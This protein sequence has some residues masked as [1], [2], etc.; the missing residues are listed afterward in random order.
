M[1]LDE[2]K[3]EPAKTEKNASLKLPDDVEFVEVVNN[4]HL[5]MPVTV[6]V[7]QNMGFG[8][9]HC[10]FFHATPLGPRRVRNFSIHTRNFG[11]DTPEEAATT[12]RQMIEFNDVIFAQDQPVVES[13]RPEDLPEDLSEELHLKGVDT[14]SVTYRRWLK[15]L[16]DELEVP[17]TQAPSG[18]GRH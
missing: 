4:W 14:L 8:L 10:L 12:A 9:R 7:E 3:L 6:H 2:P 17:P 18:S 13:Q 16:A 11:N 15:E 5:Y 1:R